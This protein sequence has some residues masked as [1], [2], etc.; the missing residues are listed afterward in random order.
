MALRV[1]IY[2]AEETS[3]YIRDNNIQIMK[4]YTDNQIFIYKSIK[5]HCAKTPKRY[6]NV[7]LQFIDL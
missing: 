5:N 2:I 6:G 3:W 4:K 7:E 1:T